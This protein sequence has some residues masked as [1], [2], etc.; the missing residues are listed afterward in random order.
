MHCVTPSKIG[1]THGRALSWNRDGWLTDKTKTKM[2]A[3]TKQTSDKHISG[4]LDRGTGPRASMAGFL[5]WIPMRSPL[6]DFI[7]GV[8]G[9]RQGKGTNCV[10]G[11]ISAMD[12][13]WVSIDG[14]HLWSPRREQGAQHTACN[15]WSEHR[16]YSA[17]NRQSSI[18]HRKW[19][20]VSK[21]AAT[22]WS[23]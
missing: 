5:P 7:Y 16:S 22:F 21:D 4:A 23:N 9:G 8:H 20:F 18:N 17:Y 3:S 15:R 11:W 2:S 1:R 14:F 12:T 6:M 10:C 19:S 13:N